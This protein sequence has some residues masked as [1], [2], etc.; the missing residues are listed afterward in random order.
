MVDQYYD[1]CYGE[2]EYRGLNFEFETLNIENNQGNALVNYADAETHFTRIIEHKHFE[3][4]DSSI[5][6][7]LQ[8]NI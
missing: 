5:K 2:L 8:K 1:Y 3:G 7:L 6:Q 4:S